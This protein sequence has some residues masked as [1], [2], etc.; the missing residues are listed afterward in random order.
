MEP[1]RLCRDV[2]LSPLPAGSCALPD[3]AVE[4]VPPLSALSEPLAPL[5][6]LVLLLL[7]FAL[8]DAWVSD[9]EA[10]CVLAEEDCAGEDEDEGDGEGAGAGASGGALC[11]ASFCESMLCCKVCANGCALVLFA[12]EI[13]GVILDESASEPM[14][15]SGDMADPV[16]PVSQVKF[17]SVPVKLLCAQDPAGAGQAGARVIRPRRAS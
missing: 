5:A 13:V 12:S 17:R 16:Y 10:A 11:A 9:C 3:A 14:N 7:L 4:V 1:L 8:L 6:L 2:E 15:D